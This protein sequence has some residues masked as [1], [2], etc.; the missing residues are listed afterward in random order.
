MRQVGRPAS[1]IWIDYAVTY[2]ATFGLVITGM[3]AFRL[4]STGF[5]D[6]GL[7]EYAISRRVIGFAQPTVALGLMVAL[8]RKIA[9][10][11]FHPQGANQRAYMLAGLAIVLTAAAI[12]AAVLVAFREQLAFTFFGSSQFGNLMLAII[13]LV[14]GWS[15]H[16][17]CYANFHGNLQMCRASLLQLFNLGL[18]PLAAIVCAPTISAALFWWGIIVMLAC[19]V[20]VLVEGLIAAEPPR[21]FLFAV[22]DLMRCGPPRV[23][24]DLAIASLMVLPAI[25]AAHQG[26]VRLGGLVAFSMTLLTLAQTPIVPISSI[27]LPRA[28]ELLHRGETD[29]LRTQVLRLLAVSMTMTL[30]IVLMFFAFT[31]PLLRLCLGSVPDELPAIA[32]IVIL[33]AVFF[34]WHT[35]LR[36]VADA[37][38]DR[39]INTRNSGFALIAF[40]VALPATNYV[41]GEAHSAAWALLVALSCLAGATSWHAWLVLRPSTTWT[42]DQPLAKYPKAA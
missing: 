26:G 38:H 28:T 10:S 36:S 7:S 3:L 42:V 16:L 8:S 12:L 34:N 15:L 5:G 1:R 23:P 27:L 25:I 39:A 2:G 4:A 11:K 6:L 13:P 31:E 21:R 9:A 32:R 24:G 40:L 14:I 41:A 18:V 33:G 35:C 29:V 17:V 20:V 19:S 30:G 37:A 22:R